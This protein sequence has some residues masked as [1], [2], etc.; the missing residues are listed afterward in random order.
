MF[1]GPLSESIIKRAQVKGIV[2]IEIV[3]F[4]DFATDKHKTVDDTPYGGGPGMLIKCDVID[5][6]LEHLKS[7]NSKLKSFT[8]LTAPSGIKYDQKKAYEYSKLDHLIIIAGHYEGFDQ[9][10]HDHLVDEEISIGDYV[11]SGGELPA[12]VIVDSIVRL[13]PGAIRAES[14]DSETFG[15]PDNFENSKLKIE[16]LSEYEQ[17]T[18][19]AEYK[20]WKVPEEL[21]S[22]NHAEIQKWR[23]KRQRRTA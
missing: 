5:S 13:I 9:R 1:V 20:G 12:M 22:G 19:P 3:N 21:L 2:E 16:N 15:K 10:I 7:K 11:L 23:E 4:R 17:Y 8:V 6:A 18:R 14:L